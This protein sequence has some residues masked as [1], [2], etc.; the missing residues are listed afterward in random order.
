MVIQKHF[1]SI[2]TGFSRVAVTVMLSVAVTG[3]PGLWTSKTT[4]SDWMPMLPDQDFYDFQLFAPPDLG[5]YNIWEREEEGFY[6][7]YD[8]LFWGI[9]IPRTV[10]TGETNTGIPIIPNQPISP[11]TIVDLNNDFLEFSRD[12]PIVIQTS[13]DS[14]QAEVITVDNISSN[15]TFFEIGADPLR[16]DLNTSWMRTKMTMGDRYE[17]GWS[18]GGRGVHLSYFQIGKQEQTFGTSSEF[19][20]NSPSQTFTFESNTGGSWWW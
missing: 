3:I 1:L 8:K 10:R 5:S 18:Y 12:N 14:V 20:V 19:A 4:A 2:I 13:E 9:T 7:N 6:F 17:G 16:L 15:S 11:F